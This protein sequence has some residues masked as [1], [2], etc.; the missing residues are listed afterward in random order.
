MP[1]PTDLPEGYQNFLSQYGVQP[2]P[3]LKFPTLAELASEPEPQAQQARPQSLFSLIGDPAALFNDLLSYPDKYERGTDELLQQLV[4]GQ[5]KVDELDERD[6]NLLNAA[7]LSFVQTPRRRAPELPKSRK[8][9]LEL[10]EAE[11]DEHGAPIPTELD[12]PEAPP[13]WWDR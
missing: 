2:I 1:K 11:L 7:V 3:P 4:H 5:K 12:L 13:R 10:E 6:R 9:E 8:P